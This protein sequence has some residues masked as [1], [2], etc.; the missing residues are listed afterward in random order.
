[1][2]DVGRRPGLGPELLAAR[3]ALTNL[4]SIEDLQGTVSVQTQ[5]LGLVDAG[6]RTISEDRLDAIE[7]QPAAEQTVGSCARAQ[8]STRT[9]PLTS[10]T[11]VSSS[12]DCISIRSLTSP[13]WSMTNID[14]FS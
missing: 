8:S 2:E 5:M 10:C 4:V 11:A 1:M 13:K 12:V 9:R 3:R 6:H 14:P 7:A